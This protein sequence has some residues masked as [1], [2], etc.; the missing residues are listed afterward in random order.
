MVDDDTSARRAERPETDPWSP[1]RPTPASKRSLVAVSH[2]I[3]AAV[4]AGPV[5]APTVVVALF[6]H[7]AYFAR[8]YAVYERIAASGAV[9][10]LAFADGEAHD[11]PPGCQLVVLDPTEPLADEWTV[12]AVGPQ[13][14]AFLVATDAHRID[15]TEHSLEAGREFIGRWGWSRVQA[16]NELARMRSALGTRLETAVGYT[17]DGLLARVMPAGGAAAASGGTDGERWATHALHRMVRRMQDAREGTRVLRAQLVD[18]HAAVAARSAAH[19]DPQSGLT[20]PEFLTRWTNTGGPTA[21]PVGVALIDVAA[22]GGAE[23]RL[24]RRAAYHA[25]RRVAA[26]VSEPLGPVDAAIRLSER[27]FALVVPGASSR[28]LAGLVDAVVEQLELSSDGYP[29]LPL[30]GPVAWTVTLTRPLPLDDLHL[31]LGTPEQPAATLAGDPIT[32]RELADDGAGTGAH[33]R[34]EPVTDRM[35]RLRVSDAATTEPPEDDVA[36]WPAPSGDDAPDA[37]PHAAPEPDAA[38]HATTAADGDAPSG[39]RP[40]PGRRGVPDPDEQG[41]PGLPGGRSGWD[42]FGASVPPGPAPSGPVPTPQD[43]D[44]DRHGTNGTGPAAEVGHGPGA[45]GSAEHGESGDPADRP[46]PSPSPSP[47]PRPGRRRL[48]GGEPALSM[49]SDLPRRRRTNGTAPG[50]S[51]GGTE[52]SRPTFGVP[53]V[54]GDTGGDPPPTAS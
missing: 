9:V 33:H 53:G 37:V 36:A 12:V 19:V 27:E 30:A 45:A 38:P 4:L 49:L 25:A 7:Q 54:P 50:T 44:G 46:S 1:D 39:P 16:A 31:A 32:V 14:G 23:Q 15:P 6:Q 24:G 21:L 43:P 20:T 17:I 51:E 18:A 41:G 13:A 47:S 34:E 40:V 26:A 29:N 42:P 28:H 2:A 8:E 35:P 52:P 5:N 10:V 3:E 48:A 22:L 11:V